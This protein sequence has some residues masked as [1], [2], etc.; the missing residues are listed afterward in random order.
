MRR[1]CRRRDRS[2]RRVGEGNDPRGPARAARV[3]E[4]VLPE[5]FT[6]TYKTYSAAKN[7]PTLR[8]R[9]KL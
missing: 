7:V 8:V 3:S 4:V 6:T 1:K 9:G 5:A 2:D